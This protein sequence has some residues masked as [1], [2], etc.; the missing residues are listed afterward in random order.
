MFK[1]NVHLIDERGWFVSYLSGYREKG[2]VFV[3]HT[4]SGF[5]YKKESVRW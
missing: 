4:C 1:Y 3:G 2:W 5:W